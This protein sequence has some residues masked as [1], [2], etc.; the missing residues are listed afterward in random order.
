[1]FSELI[2][3]FR[4]LEAALAPDTQ[5]FI[6]AIG[7]EKSPGSKYKIRV[8]KSGRSKNNVFYPDHVLRSAT[9]LLEGVR[10]FVK[11]DAEHLKGGGKNFGQ[12]LG[13]L[14]NPVFIEG[15]APNTG[16]IHA[17]F[18][19]LQSAGDVSAKILES[20]QRNMHSMFGFSIDAEGVTQQ[21]GNLKEAVRI[22]KFNSVDLIIEPGAGGQ[23]IGLIEAAATT[24]ETHA[25]SFIHIKES[26]HVT[27]SPDPKIAE[28]QNEL[29]Q[30]REAAEKMAKAAN[31]ARAEQMINGSKLPPPTKQKLIKQFTEKTDFT[32]ADV[33]KAIKDESEHVGK[34]AESG[35][36]SMPSIF[37]GEDQSEK[38]QSMWDDFFN[39]NKPAMS[40][41]ECYV[42]S[43]GDSAFTG[44][45]DRRRLT[46]ALN[47]SSFADVLGDSMNRRLL[48]EYRIQNTLDVWRF[49]TGGTVRLNDFRKREATRYGGYG[50]VP[51][52]NEGAPY[53]ALTS[54]TDEKAEY[55]PQK[56]GGTETI[57]LEMIRN[58]DQGAV[59]RVPTKM[60]RAAKRTLSKFAMNFVMNNPAVYDGVTLFHTATHKNMG[61]AA[62]SSTSLA[63][64]RLAVMN[65]TEAGSNEPLGIPPS[66]LFVPSQ[67]EETAFDLFRRQQNN[68]TTFIQSLQM[69]VIPVWCFTDPNNWYVSVN[70]S[71]VPIVELGFLDGKEEP[72]LFV[73]D[74][75]NVGSMFNNDVLT[76]KLRHI[77]GAGI[78]DYRGIYGA[79]V[80]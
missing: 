14:S 24:T 13:V 71:D 25:D 48:D 66:Y 43:T 52:V 42:H 64:A 23:L 73:Q 27:P 53:T 7:G 18:D 11:P 35:M 50:D 49:L 56:R 31:G 15:S 60:A 74:M 6:E 32:E 59:Q 78:V 3:K 5:T 19:I 44:R 57:T 28:L 22:D 38:V 9:T 70:P 45:V 69:K 12:L 76:Y 21:K 65:Q 80:P 8:I 46:E 20:F 33:E 37:M 34:L 47:S 79:I 58:D 77:Y 41:R 17:E 75:P 54:P 68:D 39:P 63:A 51:I 1:M 72:E 26:A 16:E 29:A 4:F 55:S 30:L 36:V 40:V 61:T 67:L 2:K 62:L 10:V